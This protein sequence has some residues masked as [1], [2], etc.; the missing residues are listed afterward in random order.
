MNYIIDH[1]Y[2]IHSKLS[3]CSK[4]ENQM[5][6]NI[7]KYA[8]ENGFSEICLTDHFWDRTIDVLRKNYYHE[9]DLEHILQALPLPQSEKVKFYFG[10]E[11]DMDRHMNVGI[12]EKT[13]D[14]MDFIIVPTTHMHMSFVMEEQDTSLEGR[15]DL[16]IKRFAALLDKDLPWYKVGIAHLTCPLIAKGEWKNHIDVINFISDSTFRELFYNT[17]LKGAGVEL[18]IPISKYNDEE[19]KMILR[20][21]KIA[22]ECG[23]KFY[24]GSDAHCLEAFKGAKTGF[25]KILKLLDLKES[26]KFRIYH[27]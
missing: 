24:L 2:H 9:Q 16:Y 7:L 10:C 22:A 17:A 18:N 14:I 1:D 27:Y 3:L 19:R 20:P 6:E 5:P 15:A 8:E 23:C 12:S 21:Y 11:T 26:Q 13:M 4:D 25:E